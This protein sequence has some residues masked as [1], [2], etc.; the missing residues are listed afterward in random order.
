MKRLNR[1]KLLKKMWK[2][3]NNHFGFS[4]SYPDVYIS[5]MN[6]EE[7]RSIFDNIEF[8]FTNAYEKDKEIPNEPFRDGILLVKKVQPE[9]IVKALGLE[10]DFEIL[11]AD[12]NIPHENFP[13]GGIQRENIIKNF[14]FMNYYYY[15]VL[16]E[17]IHILEWLC[18]KHNLYYYDQQDLEL[19]GSFMGWD[20]N[21]VELSEIT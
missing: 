16:H 13:F 15:L 14:G 18:E 19:F 3:L 12:A 10:H 1:A 4:Y 8:S 17:F 6:E 21:I 5:I 20:Y 11:L 2:Y 9:E 7:V